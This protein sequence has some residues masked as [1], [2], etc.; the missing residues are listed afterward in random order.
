MAEITIPVKVD[1]QASGPLK[2]IGSGAEATLNGVREAAEKT[3]RA[4]SIMGSLATGLNQGIELLKKG[5]EFFR[6][7]VLDTVDAALEFRKKNDP[8]L[9]QFEDMRKSIRLLR[10]ALGD[11]LIPILT[12]V[13]RALGDVNDGILLWLRSNR[14]L[15]ASEIVNFLGNMA[16]I[17][18]KGIGESIVLVSKVWTGWAL[19]IEST[20]GLVNTFFSI[21]TKG[22]SA[23]LSSFG[24]LI[25]FVGDEHLGAALIKASG[26]VDELAKD[27]AKSSDDA[28]KET[29]KIVKSQAELEE[30]IKDT[31]ETILGVVRDTIAITQNEIAESIAGTTRTLEEQEEIA[32]ALAEKRAENQAADLEEFL[33]QQ[34][35]KE[36][37][38]ASEQAMIEE[39][40]DAEVAAAERRQ[41]AQEATAEAI[42][43]ALADTAA[44]LV[45]TFTQG[46]M[47]S[48]ESAKAA[49]KIMFDLVKQSITALAALAGAGALG[50]SI[51]QLGPA[52]IA[53]GAI[54]ATTAIALVSAFADKFQTGGFVMGG[55]PN[56]DS[57][58]ILAQQ[59]EFVMSRN[60]V[61]GFRKFASRVLGASSGQQLADAA[62]ETGTAQIRAGDLTENT[63]IINRIWR[64][65]RFEEMK[66]SRDQ[67]MSQARLRHLGMLPT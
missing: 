34:K 61:A 63:T 41:A 31:S 40:A 30:Q 36:K 20:K 15:I 3:G 1:D 64:P 62:A 32:R 46:E 55:T 50:Q 19:I 24:E 59:G 67:A 7:G 51:A 45:E 16:I 10:A 28:V 29:A 38:W 54:L 58:P 5:F 18:T 14:K 27:F 4:F 57:V 37:A 49:L 52:G 23:A 26:L 65:G 21:I 39:L 11:A 60:D 25:S 2:A 56:R 66:M 13:S 8:V 12:G 33:E 17:L 43:V 6:I 9:K 42:G 22:V 53:V 48:R 47:T 35:E 44:A